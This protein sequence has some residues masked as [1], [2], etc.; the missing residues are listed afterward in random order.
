MVKCV[1]YP[2]PGEHSE[3]RDIQGEGRHSVVPAG[4]LPPI[5]PQNSRRWPYTFAPEHLNAPKR[6]PPNGDTHYR[7]SND[8]YTGRLSEENNATEPRNDTSAAHS[9]PETLSD[10][11]PDD[12]PMND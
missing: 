7:T 9:A 8:L 1:E 12:A 4:T 2:E 10:A 6:R 5:R 11:V 3:P